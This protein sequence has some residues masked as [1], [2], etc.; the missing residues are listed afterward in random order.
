MGNGD[1]IMIQNG[2]KKLTAF[3]T[4]LGALLDNGN[5]VTFKENGCGLISV[6]ISSDKI[7]VSAS[8]LEQVGDIFINA[9]IA[10]AFN[11]D[12]DYGGAGKTRIDG[13]DK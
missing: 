10:E 13:G 8:S 3:E 6:K 4:V 7:S 11:G 1:E 2:T 12:P 9:S 5:T